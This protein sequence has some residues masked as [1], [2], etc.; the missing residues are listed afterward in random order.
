MVSTYR[1]KNENLIKL[2]ELSDKICKVEADTDNYKDV[3]EEIA[4]VIENSEDI[5]VDERDRDNKLKCYE[6]M[7]SK[8]KLII[9]NFKIN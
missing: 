4:D 9:N 2:K 5:I 1:D 6:S 8:L 3:V 7:F